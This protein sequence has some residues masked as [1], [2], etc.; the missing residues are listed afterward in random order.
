MPQVSLQDRIP[1]TAHLSPMLKCGGAG[2]LDAETPVLKQ[3]TRGSPQVAAVKAASERQ[4]GL[5]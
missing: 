4:G 1:I 2:T 3:S 5:Q